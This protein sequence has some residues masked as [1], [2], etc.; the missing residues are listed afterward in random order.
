[1][2]QETI[3]QYVAG[4]LP[5]AEAVAFE[6]YCL[7]NPEFAQQVE[8]EQRLKTGMAL[9]ARDSTAEYATSN[10]PLR[11]N[12]AAAAGVLL[13]VFGLF[14]AWTHWAPAVTPPIMAAVTSDAERSG[15]SLR[16][17]MVRGLESTPTL[18]DGPVRVEIVG[19]F[20]LGASYSVALKR[21][22]EEGTVATVATLESLH[23]TSPVTLEVMVDGRQLQPGAYSLRVRGQASDE[24][25]LDFGFMKF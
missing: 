4:R 18:K 23:P 8:F 12:L 21:L 14:Y 20:E 2:N 10:H 3:E 13:A 15:A 22:D 25:S 11:R 9:S 17:A 6:D 1:V 16:L 19:L 7:L 24:E 5:E